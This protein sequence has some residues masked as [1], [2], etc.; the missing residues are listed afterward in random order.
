MVARYITIGGT[1]Y[2]AEFN[3]NA[4]M[5]FLVE[6]GND[7]MEGV[8][9]L[10]DL[11]PSE[12][13]ALAAAAIVEGERLD[14]RK[15]SLTKEDIG[16]VITA[17]SMRELVNIFVEQSGNGGGDSAKSQDGTPAKKKSII[18]RSGK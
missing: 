17:D 12:L 7:T 1:R 9:H 5:A 18:R 15:C 13:T 8:M 14:G 4:I 3:W 16:C 2:R 6:S 10:K 11:K